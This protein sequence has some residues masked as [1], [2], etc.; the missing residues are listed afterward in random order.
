MN[1][2]QTKSKQDHFSTLYWQKQLFNRHNKINLEKLIM[3]ILTLQ[4]VF[5][6]S[7]LES[8][9]MSAHF[10]LVDPHHDWFLLFLFSHPVSFSSLWPQGLQ[11]ARPPCPSTSPRVCPSSCPLNQWFHLAISSSD[12]L[13][14]FCPQFF[15]ASGSFPMNQLFTSGDWNSGASVSASVLPLSIQLWFPIRL[16]GLISLL[17]KRL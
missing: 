15:P 11:Q 6:A 12:A 8:L 9:E 16:T 4:D 10:Q 14:S 1:A 7:G 17:S 5:R 2:T 3:L 13:F